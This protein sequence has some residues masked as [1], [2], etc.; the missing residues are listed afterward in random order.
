MLSIFSELKYS[1]LLPLSRPRSALSTFPRIYSHLPEIQTSEEITDRRHGQLKISY[2]KLELQ[3]EYQGF[4]KGLSDGR[5]DRIKISQSLLPPQHRIDLRRSAMQDI[6]DKR[7]R[8]K[9]RSLNF[10]RCAP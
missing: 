6:V 5:L 7:S 2:H 10:T 1:K 9:T 3:I 8:E 4:Q